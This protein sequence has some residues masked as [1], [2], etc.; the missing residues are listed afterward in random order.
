MDH[1]RIGLEALWRLTHGGKYQVVDRLVDANGSGPNSVPVTPDGRTFGTTYAGGMFD[2][3]VVFSVDSAGS[4]WPRTG[5]GYGLAAQGG[6]YGDGKP[7]ALTL[8]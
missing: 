1:D 3:G 7:W 4:R 5:K 8:P 2:K 6:A